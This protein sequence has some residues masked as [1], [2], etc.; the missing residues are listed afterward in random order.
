[1]KR[2]RDY[3]NDEKN[4]DDKMVVIVVLG[5]KVSMQTIN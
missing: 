3:G 2:Q 4:D 5:V 1:M